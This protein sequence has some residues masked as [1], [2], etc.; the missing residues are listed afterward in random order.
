MSSA[1]R[2]EFERFSS[3]GFSTGGHGVLQLTV[4]LSKV[5]DAFFD[6]YTVYVYNTETVAEVLSELKT[7]VVDQS[8]WSLMSSGDQFLEPV[9]SMIERVFLQLAGVLP[10]YLLASEFP[11][12]DL[13]ISSDGANVVALLS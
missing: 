6:S 11:A 12:L 7:F 13:L 5:D 1:I 10:S 4:S 9:S 3:L 2:P 8:L